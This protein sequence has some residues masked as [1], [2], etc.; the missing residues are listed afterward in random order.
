M[1]YGYLAN[2]DE[3]KFDD[4]NVSP[5]S[6]PGLGIELDEETIKEQSKEDINWHNLVWRH[7]DRSIA[8]W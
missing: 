8:E 2:P 1:A 7:S 4:G 3:F 5:P 6:G